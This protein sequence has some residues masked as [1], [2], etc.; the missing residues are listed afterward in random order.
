MQKVYTQPVLAIIVSSFMGYSR[1]KG[2]TKSWRIFKNEDI[3][4]FTILVIGEDG[5]QI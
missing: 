3:K 2:S 4:A 5:E 1:N